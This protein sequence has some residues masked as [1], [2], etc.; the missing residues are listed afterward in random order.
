MICHKYQF[1]NWY[2][3]SGLGVVIFAL[4]K[5]LQ[6]K[7]TRLCLFYGRS[8]S[9]YVTVS[10]N[11]ITPLIQ[12]IQN[13]SLGKRYFFSSFI[14]ILVIWA[15]VVL[16]HSPDVWWPQ[17]GTH[18]AGLMSHAIKTRGTPMTVQNIP[19]VSACSIAKK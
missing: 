19:P 5:F 3:N 6:S 12:F 2:F 8:P 13:S 14:S 4:F 18:A 9:P 17:P 16:C 11:V 10:K 1:C 7:L 15:E